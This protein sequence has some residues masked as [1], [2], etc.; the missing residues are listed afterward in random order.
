ALTATQVATHYALR[1]STAPTPVTLQIQASDPDGDPLTFSATGLPTGLSINPTTGL[2]SGT[3][4]GAT[5]GNYPVTVTVS[6]GVA[7]ATQ[8]FTWIVPGSESADRQ[9]LCYPSSFPAVFVGWE[10]S[11]SLFL[12]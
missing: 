1:L 6:D 5:P 11:I 12:A 8:S 10:E 7:A 9:S 4:S 3:L 2:I